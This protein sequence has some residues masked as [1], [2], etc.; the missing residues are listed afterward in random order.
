MTKECTFS[1]LSLIHYPVYAACSASVESKQSDIDRAIQTRSPS[2]SWEHFSRHVSVFKSG[3]SLVDWSD[4][5]KPAN[6]LSVSCME[7]FLKLLLIDSPHSWGSV[8]RY[9]KSERNRI[10]NFF[11]IPNI[12]D[13]ESDTFF[14]TNFFPIPIPILFS[15]PKFYETDT[16]TFFD[17]KIIRNR[18]RYFFRYQNISKP[19]PILFSI[20]KNFETDTDTISKF[21]NWEV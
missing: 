12:F 13:T 7:A 18:Y 21:R 19:I 8:W 2:E 11:P 6:V 3:G 20:P 15:I 1:Y 10:R 5:F 14:D 17:T 4:H 16:D 9:P